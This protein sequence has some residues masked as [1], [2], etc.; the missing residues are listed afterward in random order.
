VVPL[1]QPVNGSATNGHREE[2]RGHQE[3]HCGRGWCRWSRQCH[4]RDAH[5]LRHWKGNTRYLGSFKKKVQKLF[6]LSNPTLVHDK[7]VFCK[8]NFVFAF[9]YF[10]FLIFYDILLYS[11]HVWKL[12]NLV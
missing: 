4:R 9:S 12:K 3:I 6:F 8:I 10:N 1:F 11:Y 7:F 2:L 5:P